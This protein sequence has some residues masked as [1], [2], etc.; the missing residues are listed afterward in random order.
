V[1]QGGNAFVTVFNPTGTS[2]LIFSTFWGGTL[3]DRGTSIALD[4]ASPPNVYLAG[5]TTSSVAF[6]TSPG[7]FQRTFGGL[8]DAFVAKFSPASL[9]GTVSVA[10]TSLA[11]GSQTINTTSAAQTV[12]L[13]NGSNSTLTINS[14]PTSG[15]NAS[16]FTVANSGGAT[17][18]PVAPATLAAGAN[19]VLDVT[20][21][22]TTTAAESATLTINDTNAGGSLQQLVSLTGT[23]TASGTPDFTVSVSP[24]SATVTAGTAAPFTVTVTSITGFSAAVTLAC[25]GAP[26]FSTCTLNPTSVTPAANSTAM[27]TGNITTLARTVV[28]PP[29]LFRIPPGLPGWLWILAGIAMAFL[30]ILMATRPATRKLAFGFGLLAIL[31]LT[32][33]SGPIHTGTPAGSYKIVVTAT[34]GA[35]NHPANFTLIVN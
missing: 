18:C 2:P 27:S 31:S 25:S 14:F 16:D 15:S 13:T 19:C 34:S 17:A 12:T 1:Q 30:A 6:P 9:A 33:C 5:A 4:T 28:P 24:A 35:L 8:Q 3:Q 21:T 32:S 23:G 7:A 26:A 29:F 10:P 20:F 22:P 11:F